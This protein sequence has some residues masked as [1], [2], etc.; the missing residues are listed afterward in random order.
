M[1]QGPFI[2]MS[3]FSSQSYYDQDG[4]V[5]SSN[6][7]KTFAGTSFQNKLFGEGQTSFS[8]INQVSDQDGK[9]STKTSRGKKRK[10]TTRK[11]NL[12]VN[13]HNLGI[14]NSIQ[15]MYNPFHK[16]MLNKSL[17]AITPVM[18]KNSKLNIPKIPLRSTKKPSLQIEKLS[19]RSLSKS[20]KSKKVSSSSKKKSLRSRRSKST[21]S[22]MKK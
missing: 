17:A 18:E 14:Y 11:Y 22:S 5:N 9:L 19:S 15:K 8:T 16:K 20:K 4:L 7:A 3:S 21:R 13:K 6:H 12:N 2:N 10:P 1:T